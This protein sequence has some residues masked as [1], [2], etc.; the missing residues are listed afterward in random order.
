MPLSVF[1][2]GQLDGAFSQRPGAFNIKMAS[3]QF[4]QRVGWVVPLETPMLL[5]LDGDGLASAALRKLAL[6]GLDS[7]VKGFLAG[8]MGAW[9]ALGM[10]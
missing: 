9:T 6:I 10:G 7:R 5:V 1:S 3:P 2:Q 8:G 4:E